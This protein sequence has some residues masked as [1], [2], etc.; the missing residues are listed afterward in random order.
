[1]LSHLRLHLDGFF[2]LNFIRHFR[3]ASSW[4]ITSGVRYGG[5]DVFL[6]PG[7]LTLMAFGM[8]DLIAAV[9]MCSAQAGLLLS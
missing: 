2:F 3:V 5:S 6:L 9:R 7:R 1:M 8:I 4:I